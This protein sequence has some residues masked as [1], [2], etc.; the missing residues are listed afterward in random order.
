M[1]NSPIAKLSEATMGYGDQVV[2]KNLNL[3]IRGGD[4]VA[5]VG[6]NGSGKTT[7][8]KGL[9]GLIPLFSGERQL[10]GKSPD[11]LDPHL[12]SYLPQKTALNKMIPL[13]VTEFLSLKQKKLNR[14]E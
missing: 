1:D 3:E 5:M 14:S 13:T 7:I 10:F 4:F 6:P 11:K 9:L 8:M 2:I 12:V